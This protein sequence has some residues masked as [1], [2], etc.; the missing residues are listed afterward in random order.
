[1]ATVAAQ[2]TSTGITAPNYSDILQQLK[3][4]YWA[5][6]GSDA[7]LD[8]DSQDG[9]F[10]AELA[11]AIF[12]CNQNV[13][14]IYASFAPSTARGVQLSRLVKLNGLRRS[15]PTNSQ[16]VVSIGGT[17]GTSIVNGVVGDNANLGT[18]WALPALV[19]IPIAGTVDVT[20]TATTPGA[21]PAAP[22][23]LTKI[24]TPTLGWQ[25]VTNA[26]LAS[27]GQA[28]ET[29]A[30]LRVR[31]SKSVALPAMTV[32]EGIF[33]VV[34]AVVGVSRLKIYENS[35][36][37]NNS[38][39]LTPH[40]ISVIVAGGD[41]TAIATAIALKKTP[42]GRTNGTTSVIVTDKNGVPNTIRFYPLTTVPLK[43]QISVHPLVGYVSTTG[44]LLKQT[45]V[46]FVNGFDIGE[47][48]YLARLYSPA[49]L[50][51]AGLGSTFVVTAITQAKVAG[52]LA[53]ADV[54][55]A[56]NEGATLDLSQVTLVLV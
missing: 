33:A 17:V 22:G 32:L 38:D 11:Q 5:I 45:V 48:S 30:Q 1:M 23:S 47:D 2:I 28:V 44:D 4:V 7:V 8:P 6:Y 9:Q 18:Q 49:N 53:A 19:V 14:D 39:G 15:V 50:S 42:G 37:V 36:D 20:A 10:L 25:T 26:V 16:A 41:A 29:D 51:G 40:S 55:I 3:I 24:L 52:A 13:I 21:T 35:D 34:D 12:D 56:F 46:D 43:M 27:P 54:V 31:Q